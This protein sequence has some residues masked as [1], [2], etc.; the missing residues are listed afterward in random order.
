VDEVLDAR[1]LEAAVDLDAARAQREELA[2]EAKGLAHRRRRVERPEVLIAVLGHPPGDDQPRVLLVG[3]ELEERV[4]LVVAEDDVVSG[5][6]L[7]DQVRLED[8]RLELVVG[9]DVVEIPDLPHERV[10][11]RI[12]HPRILKVRPHPAPQRRRL[13]H[14]DD[15]AL[16]VLV[17]IHPRPIRH[18]LELLRQRHADIVI[19]ARGRLGDAP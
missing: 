13:P 5:P 12:P 8:H 18:P 2:H 7:L 17:L 4:V 1:A 11:L 19:R 3:G 6:V 16:G 14:V 9:D 15:L 10:G